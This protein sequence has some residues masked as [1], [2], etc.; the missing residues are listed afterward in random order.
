MIL[1]SHTMQDELLERTKDLFVSVSLFF[2][3]Y[4]II[5]PNV[6]AGDPTMFCWPCAFEDEFGSSLVSEIQSNDAVLFGVISYLF[7]LSRRT[8][9]VTYHLCVGV[10]DVDPPMSDFFVQ[11][12]GSWDVS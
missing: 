11:L 10:T 2:T 4:K 7:F 9:S 3:L 1:T 6:H 5:F 12:L 8:S